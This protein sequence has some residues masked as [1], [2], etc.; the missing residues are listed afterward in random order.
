MND[1]MVS[2]SYFPMVFGKDSVTRIKTDKSKEE[3]KS[4]ILKREE[5]KNMHFEVS[6]VVETVDEYL[7][8]FEIVEL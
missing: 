5:S 4:I 8:E 3:V 6:V 2:V 7:A 1:F